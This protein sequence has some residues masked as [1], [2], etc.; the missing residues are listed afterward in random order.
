MRRVSLNM[1]GPD[2]KKTERIC[3]AAGCLAAVIFVLA[4]FS[5]G[6]IDPLNTEWVIN[7]GGDNFQHY[8]GWRFFR[9]SRWTRY[10]LFMRDLNYPVG[11]SVIVTDSNPLFCLIFKLFR[12]FL[13]ETFQFNGIW[14]LFSYIMIAY[15]AGKIGWRLSG[16]LW[17]SLIIT[18]LCILN[19]VI[20]QRALIHDTLTAH[21]LI[22]AAVYLFLD[23]RNRLNPAGWFVLIWTAMLVHIYFVPMIGFIFCLQLIRMFIMRVPLKRTGITVLSAAAALLTGYFGMG[24]AHI[25]PQ[26]DSYGELSM[27]LNAFFNPDGVSAILRSRPTMPLQYEGFNYWGLGLILLFAAGIAA[28]RRTYFQKILPYFL[29]SVLL[30]LLAVSNHAYFDTGSVWRIEIPASVHSLLSVFRSS[31]RLAW[32]LYYLVL[33]A[34]VYALGKSRLSGKAVCCIMAVCLMVQ[35]CDLGQYCVEA[36]ERFRAPANRIAGLPAGLETLIPDGTAHLFVSDVGGRN[37][38]ALALFAADRH[39]TYNRMANARSIRKVFGGDMV[40]MDKLTCAGLEP[41]SVYI[42]FTEDVPDELYSCGD[43]AALNGWTVI[44]SGK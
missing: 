3:I 2:D 14:I 24:Y 13:P 39:M 35:A 15:F 22:L 26:S 28:G 12:N 37:A 5:A 6:N 4:V 32:P 30:V 8:I 21:W 17:V 36:A 31:G 18:L 33:F 44:R 20:L 11:T 19:P 9:E 41:D 29:P 16:D 27:N 38:D 23:A 7:G 10:L 25:L 1:R 43:V 40:E 42:W 34:S